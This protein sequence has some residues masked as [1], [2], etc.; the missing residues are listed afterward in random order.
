MVVPLALVEAS[1]EECASLVPWLVLVEPPV[2][3]VASVLVL[4]VEES[5]QASGSSGKRKSASR[6]RRVTM[7]ESVQV[8]PS[9]RERNR[10]L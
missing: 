4:S 9:E 7:R 8:D 5:P 2:V 1:L 3:V 6:P 10:L